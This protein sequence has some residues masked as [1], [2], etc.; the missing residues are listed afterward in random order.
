MVWL[1]PSPEPSAVRATSKPVVPMGKKPVEVDD[2]SGGR[3]DVDVVGVVGQRGVKQVGLSVLF[4]RH[5]Q[6]EGRVRFRWP[7]CPP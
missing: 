5:R 3:D 4:R 2:R 7:R 6:G 1:P